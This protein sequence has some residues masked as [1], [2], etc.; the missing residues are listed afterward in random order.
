MVL[1]INADLPNFKQTS[2]GKRAS[3]EKFPDE[4]FY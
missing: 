3:F 1:T 4:Q 2:I